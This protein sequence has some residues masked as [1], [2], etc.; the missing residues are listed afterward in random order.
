MG[1]VVRP[2]GAADL[3]VAARINRAAFSKFFGIPDPAK[4]RIGADVIGPRWRLWPEAGLALDL[5]GA[6]AAVALMMRW[7]SVAI[8]GPVTVAPEYWSKGLARAL[9]PKLIATIDE[10]RF[11]FAGLFTHPQSPKHIRLYES[12]GFRM[13]RITAVM[14]KPAAG[15]P[16]PALEYSRAE[17]TERPHL[18]EAV[19]DL[20]DGVFPGLDVTEEIADIARHGLGQTLLLEND[21]RVEGV[22]LCHAGRGSEASEGQVLVK[23]AAARGGAD[24]AVRFERLL[25]AC[26]AYAA[27][28][29]AAQ[30]VAGT[31]TGRAEAYEIMQRVG[32]RT[33]MHGVAMTRPATDGY[34]RPGIF[35]I[36]DWR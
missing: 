32:Y 24:G 11:A 7:G 13:Q 9:M 14:A 36:D 27:S 20:T 17:A 15:G 22:A 6:L 29:G 30:I 35:A 21:G 34:N 19:R 18:L 12:Y 28:R 23:F 8:L 1:I 26:E 10:A 5:D 33:L 4:F 16:A 3:P 25:R 31:N 2:L